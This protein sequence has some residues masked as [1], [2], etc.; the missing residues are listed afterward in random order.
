MRIVWS[1]V[2]LAL[3]FAAGHLVPSQ[4]KACGGFFCN[5]GAPVSQAAERILFSKNADGTVTAVVQILYQGPAEEFAWMLPVPGS[6]EVRVSSDLA[7][8]RLQM[9][10][11]PVYQLQTVVEGECG[12]E[13]DA[14]GG[15]AAD[16]SVVA[17][18]AAGEQDAGAPPVTIVDQG[19]VGPYDYV[20]V[21]LDPSLPDPGDVAVEWLQE[22]GYDVDD[23]GRE[24]LGPYL[25]DGLNLIAFRLT[26]DRSSGSIRPVHLTFEDDEPMI[27]IRP[28]AVA[29]NQDMGVLVWVLGE[30]RAV[31]ANY[32]SLEL[33]E[34]LINWFNP[35]PTYD[36]VV[37]AAANEAGGQGFVTELA[38]PT[39]SLSNVVL[40][41]WDRD[42]WRSIEEQDWTGREG[43]LLQETGSRL[44]SWDG[45]ADVVRRHVPVPEGADPGEFYQCPGC[46]Y[47]EPLGNIEDIDGFEPEA[48]LDDVRSEVFEPMDRTQ[49][50][51]DAHPYVTRLYTTM[52]P[53]EM[54][55][56]P[57]FGFNET[58]GDVSNRHAA[59]RVIEC[60]P[61]VT[62]GEAPW[63]VELESGDVVRGEGSTW[64]FQ[65]GDGHMPVN[66]RVLQLERAGMGSV[67]T[68]NTASISAT[69]GEHNA[70]V[71]PPP[72]AHSGSCAL[73]GGP[74]E[75]APW[76]PAVFG[77]AGLWALARRRR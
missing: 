16:A 4:A 36:A 45:F 10:T 7:F 49:D 40:P 26:K 28:T 55:V 52:S 66:R 18:A 76:A 43:E 24:R 74:A 20:T 72:A 32:L 19:N 30:S 47:E 25:A 50:L 71:P 56:D 1:V 75:S 39:S 2:V 27:P 22:N 35:T 64:P 46:Y 38:G 41:D 9:A 69:L 44:G 17:D 3:A 31:P 48:F 58:L 62:M 59:T 29:A 23:M 63:R 8:Q 54:T 11:N 6:P 60:T 73:A 21:S 12:V 77:L 13:D 70:S 15:G 5:A 51:L 53:H 33:N 34:A 67:V 57:I 65:A 14:F 61:A 42:A 68:D 37:T